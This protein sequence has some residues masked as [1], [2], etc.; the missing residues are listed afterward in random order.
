MSISTPSEFRQRIAVGATQAR[1]PG[2]S[3]RVVCAPI[4]SPISSRNA[5]PATSCRRTHHASPGGDIGA[6]HEI[7]WPPPHKTAA[8]KAI[9]ISV[10]VAEADRVLQRERDRI[11]LQSPAMAQQPHPRQPHE[12]DEGKDPQEGRMRIEAGRKGVADQID[13]HD[14]GSPEH[15]RYAHREHERLVGRL[16]ASSER[17]HLAVLDHARDLG[18]SLGERQRCEH[19]HREHEQPRRK[20][21]AARRHAEP[22]PYREETGEGQ[23][24]EDRLAL[25]AERIGHGRPRDRGR[26]WLRRRPRPRRSAQSSMPGRHRRCRGR[27]RWKVDPPPAGARASTNAGGRHR[28]PTGH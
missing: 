24:V 5:G 4:S 21:N 16:V 19:E 17:L 12:Q 1:P 25:E 20:S 9:I 11:V 27:H 15:G 10:R 14:E 8:T 23:G 28:D 26:A 3:L 2:S 22:Q 7:P 13:D 6:R 18:A